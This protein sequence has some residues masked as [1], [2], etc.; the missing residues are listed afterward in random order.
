[1][2]LLY[3]RR[4]CVLCSL[5]TIRLFMRHIHLDHLQYTNKIAASNYIC[6]CWDGPKCL[7]IVDRQI[8][9]HEIVRAAFYRFHRESFGS[10]IWFCGRCNAYH[11]FFIAFG[12]TANKIILF[13]AATHMQLMLFIQ[14][15]TNGIDHIYIGFD[16]A[17]SRIGVCLSPNM[18]GACREGGT[19][20]MDGALFDFH[21]DQMDCLACVFNASGVFIARNTHTHPQTLIDG[22][23]FSCS[24]ARQRSSGLAFF[25]FASI[26]L[27]SRSLGGAACVISNFII[28]F[29]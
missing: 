29:I 17:I 14:S 19:R 15:D 20:Q 8:R 1:M 18:C 2:T 3:C 26:Q 6:C 28:C 11:N 21:V 13:S 27:P 22:H 16:W 9:Q 23:W 24:F 12:R 10:G 25:F 4:R 7:Q 5:Y